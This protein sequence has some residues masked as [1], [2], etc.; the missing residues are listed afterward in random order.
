MPHGGK[1]QENV[2]AGGSEHRS[3]FTISRAR[4]TVVVT[5]HGEIALEDWT[6]IDGILHDIIDAQG[7]LDV[8]VD[9]GEVTRLEPDAMPLIVHAA[10]RA[11]GH[12]GR[13]R[14][15]DRA[16]HDRSWLGSHGAA[17]S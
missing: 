17:D 2:T 9:L 6:R 10:H 4:G 1:R 5:V 3:S 15:A 13:L 14:L 12:G 11:H 7:N 8:V 16:C